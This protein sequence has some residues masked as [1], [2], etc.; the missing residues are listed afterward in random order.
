[1]YDRSATPTPESFAMPEDCSL[2]P[3]KGKAQMTAAELTQALQ[4]IDQLW[5]STKRPNFR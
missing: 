2:G 5:R 4:L 1:L 3:E